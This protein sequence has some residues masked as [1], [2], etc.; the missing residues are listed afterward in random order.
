MDDEPRNNAAATRPDG[1]PVGTPFKKGNPGR[2]K[3]SRNKLGEAFLDDLYA[4]WQENGKRVIEVVRAEKPDQYLKVVA[5]ILPKDLNVNVNKYDDLTDE[6]LRQ[7]LREL[8]DTIGPLLGD[9]GDDV[10][11]DGVAAQTTH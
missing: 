2:Q 8:H 4:D 5:S 3:G 10:V 9:A 6:E 1:M 7:R 11:D